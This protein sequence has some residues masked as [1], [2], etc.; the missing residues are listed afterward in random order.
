MHLN[1]WKSFLQR[2]KQANL[3][4]IWENDVY[5]NLTSGVHCTKYVQVYVSAQKGY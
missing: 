5:D 3:P 1:F 2:T 4:Y